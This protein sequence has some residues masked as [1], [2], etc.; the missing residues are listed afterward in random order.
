MPCKKLVPAFLRISVLAL[1]A[2]MSLWGQPA[3]QQAMPA[4][5][6]GWSDWRYIGECGGV[7]MSVALSIDDGRNDFEVKM[8]MENRDSHRVAVRLIADLT[9]DHGETKQYHPGTIMN[10]GKFAE[11]GATAPALSFG[12][13]FQSAVFAKA[14]PRIT[15]NG[16]PRR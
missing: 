16:V 4:P 1:T 3:G 6:P 10:P 7:R 8:R 13:V 2:T 5:F 15:N 9:N 11:G 14:P 12:T